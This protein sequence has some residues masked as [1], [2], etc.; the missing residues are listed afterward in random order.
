MLSVLAYLFILCICSVSASQLAS[1]VDCSS[2]RSR[3]AELWGGKRLFL[4]KLDRDWLVLSN[5]NDPDTLPS[6]NSTAATMNGGFDPRDIHCGVSRRGAL[7]VY[8]AAAK[9]PTPQVE[10]LFKDPTLATSLLAAPA[11]EGA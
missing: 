4:E 9:G 1:R 6:I 8:N 10:A 2:F 11:S 7:I 5:T 3:I